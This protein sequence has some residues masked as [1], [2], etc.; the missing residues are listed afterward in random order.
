MVNL[1]ND[2]GLTQSIFEFGFKI[3]IIIFILT[4][5]RVKDQPES[6]LKS[7]PRSTRSSFKIIII[8]IFIITLTWVNSLPNLWPGPDPCRPSSQVLNLL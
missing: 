7:G 6:W 3:M 8:I 2:L 1:T 4:L 5:T